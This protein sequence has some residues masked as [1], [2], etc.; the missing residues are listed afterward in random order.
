MWQADLV[1]LSTPGESRRS[2]GVCAFGSYRVE[3][4][5]AGS[6]HDELWNAADGTAV[7]GVVGHLRAGQ[8]QPGSACVRGDE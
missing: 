3:Q 5:L 6:V 7:R 4:P 8:Q 1:D 2:D